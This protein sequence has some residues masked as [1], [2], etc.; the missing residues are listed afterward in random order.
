MA[1]DHKFSKNLGKNG[2]VDR[3]TCHEV[4]DKG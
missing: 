4:T 2:K 1:G 3:T